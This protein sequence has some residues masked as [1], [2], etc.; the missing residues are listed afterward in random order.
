MCIRV[1]TW[2][3]AEMRAFSAMISP[4]MKKMSCWGG[5]SGGLFV[6]S[7]RVGQNQL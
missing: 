6:L 5:G 4:E 1:I 3:L 2:M 7:V